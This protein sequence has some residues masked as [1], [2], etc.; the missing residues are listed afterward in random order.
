MAQDFSFD[1]VS[2]VDLQAADD[3][4]NAGAKEIINR[5]DFKGSVSGMSLDKKDRGNH[6]ELGR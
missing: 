2:K 4:V 3:A 5:F 1:V 6:A